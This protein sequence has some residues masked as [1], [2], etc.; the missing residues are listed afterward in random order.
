LLCFVDVFSSGA[1]QSREKKISPVGIDSVLVKAYSLY[2][3]LGN[4]PFAINSLI[5]CEQFSACESSSILSATSLSG[6]VETGLLPGNAGALA[7]CSFSCG[8]SFGVEIERLRENLALIDD[9]LK[10]S[11][12]ERNLGGVRLLFLRDSFFTAAN[13]EGWRLCSATLG[14][15]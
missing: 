8:R 3:E 6:Y 7:G 14:G 15:V 4:L 9:L 5:S 2:L 12:E 13:G 10:L 1:L 11:I